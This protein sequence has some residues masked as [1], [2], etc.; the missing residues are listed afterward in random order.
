[1]NY[2]PA[3]SNTALAVS[4]LRCDSP[5]HFPRPSHKFRYCCINCPLVRLSIVSQLP[6]QR[7]CV[8]QQWWASSLVL[9]YFKNRLG[10]CSL[11]WLCSLNY[12]ELNAV[13]FQGFQRGNL[14]CHSNF[15]LLFVRFL[16]SLHNFLWN[17]SVRILKERY[18]CPCYS[19]IQ[20]SHWFC[21]YR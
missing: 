10:L 8:H 11:N 12:Q 14:L 2:R 9:C 5:L 15:M 13:L 19:Y 20:F 21:K 16:L 3:D 18:H 7:N 6:M 4:I 17:D 1:M